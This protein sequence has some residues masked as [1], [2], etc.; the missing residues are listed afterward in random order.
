[1]FFM[2]LLWGLDAAS[3][4]D[5]PQALPYDRQRFTSQSGCIPRSDHPRMRHLMQAR[6]KNVSPLMVKEP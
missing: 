4:L 1:M 2:P 5:S 3:R 6:A